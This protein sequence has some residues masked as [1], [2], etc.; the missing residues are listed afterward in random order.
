M[1]S[2]DGWV[3]ENEDICNGEKERKELSRGF[4]SLI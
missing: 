4:L 3:M 1:M 2:V